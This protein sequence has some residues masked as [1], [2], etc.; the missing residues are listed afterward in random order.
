MEIYSGELFDGS[1]GMNNY[2]FDNTGKHL[3]LLVLVLLTDTCMCSM[4]ACV[5][6]FHWSI[7]LP[8]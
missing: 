2:Y 7:R 8:H 6:H 1:H 3:K 5:L 4:L